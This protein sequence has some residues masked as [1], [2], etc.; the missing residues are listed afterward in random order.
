MR[1]PNFQSSRT[2]VG[3]IVALIHG[4]D[5]SELRGLVAEK[6]IRDDR[7]DA[8]AREGGDAGSPRVV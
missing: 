2:F 8:E 4:R 6:L 3:E 1:R 5:P 7:V